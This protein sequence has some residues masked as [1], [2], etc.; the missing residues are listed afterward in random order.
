MCERL[1][2]LVVLT[3]FC[4]HFVLAQRDTKFELP[5]EQRTGSIRR[6]F[7]LCHS[8][9]DIGFTRP[10]DEV[11]RDYKDNLDDAIRL[12]R[13]NPD[14]KW[15]IESAWMLEEWLR[16]TDDPTLIAELGSLLR[17]GRMGLGV[18]F[19]NMHSGLMAAEETNRL[20]YL[21][22]K[23][24][25]K[26]GLTSAVAF[27][28]DVP[29]F[30]WA[31]PRVFAG[32][33]VKRLVMGL[34]LFIGGGNS[35][36]VAK[37]P[38]YWVGPDGSRV[39]TY[40]TYDSYVEGYRWKLGARFPLSD[41]EQSVPRRLA[42][43][44]KN[45]YK[46]D[47]YLLMA[48]SGDNSSP[49]GAYGVLQRIREWNKAHPELPMQMVTA[50]EFF[51]HLIEKYGD[52]FPE[53]AG[54]AAGHWEL[55]KLRVPEAAAKMRQV[56]NLLPAA[57]TA[58]AV[59]SLVTKLQYPKFDLSEA[60]QS[61]LAFHE[62]TA[63]AGGG[64][65]GYFSRA[66]ADWSN[67]AHYAAALNGFSNTEQTLRRSILRIALP[68]E[69]HPLMNPVGSSTES[70]V[71][72]VYNGLAWRRGGP[73][74]VDRL[75]SPLREGSLRV[76]DL[77]T[78]E[79]V[80]YEDVPGT[81]R[82]ILL[83]AKD[84]PGVGYKAYGITK[85]TGST[86]NSARVAFPVE[87]SWNTSGWITSIAQGQ[88]QLSPSDTT[89]PIGRLLIS[90]DRNDYRADETGPPHIYTQEGPL[91]RRVEMTRAGSALPLT[92]VTTYRDAPY[93]DLRFDVDL[94]AAQ[95]MTGTNSR[96]AIS[97]PFRSEKLFVDGAGFVI[98]VPEDVLPG[99]GAPQF[100]PVGF[101]HYAQK[102]GWGATVANID[103]AMLR[104]DGSFLLAA[105]NF[106][107]ATRDE[108]LVKLFRTEPRSTPVQTFRFRVAI[109][110]GDIASWKR[111]GS[112]TN[113]PLRAVTS[114]GT[115]RVPQRG[116]LEISD[117]RVQVLA[118]K[119]SESR[120]DLYVLRL[121]ESTGGA[122]SG[123]SVTSPLKFTSIELANLVEEPSGRVAD[124]TKLAF[125]P[126]ET[127]TL[128]LKVEAPKE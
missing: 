112:E 61:L 70:S 31:F 10:P 81:K 38:F 97:L 121:Q 78:G 119:Q 117:T 126:W 5:A 71:V 104:P 4:A 75:P 120:P 29:G 107:S 34:N 73:V 24:R 6:I 54:D 30:T 88:R 14:F 94:G 85:A 27:Q 55:V 77:T 68:G 56:S 32:S 74:T 21:G 8:H 84:V 103:A 92:V 17:S 128:L 110:E 46:Y 19:A 64:W 89:K 2:R 43:L 50:E 25:S 51:D 118:F 122:V 98:R 106:A 36:G 48:S 62:H 39:L 69:E 18:A 3:G 65:P 76:E 16:R 40:F 45:G 101:V 115:P 60:W 105:E 87:V 86:D 12:T 22:H 53:A 47:T 57:E 13:A 35:L 116:F 79:R 83:F 125:Q 33:G 127:K 52:K 91:T 58:A 37:N 20:N 99:G 95:G 93:I 80:P 72:I 23:F 96:F 44:E 9:L 7:V 114:P 108:G 66:D 11:A 28:N 90:Q 26:W 59:S 124:L 49:I 123:V 15:T 102:G 111:F 82:Q 100:T 109:Q 67:T 113:V 41:L 42:W 1:L 63:D